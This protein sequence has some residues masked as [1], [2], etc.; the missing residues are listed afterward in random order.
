MSCFV[1]C[2]LTRKGL[3]EANSVNL[4]KPYSQENN[5]SEQPECHLD[6][7]WDVFLRL[8]KTFFQISTNMLIF[9]IIYSIEDF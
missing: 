8:I 3:L 1:F 6:Q 2:F 9:L 5:P 7:N 4:T